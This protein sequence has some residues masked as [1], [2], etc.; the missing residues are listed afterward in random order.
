MITMR[1]I[2]AYFETNSK[3]CKCIFLSEEKRPVVKTWTSSYL[4]IQEELENL[5]F[6]VVD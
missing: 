4:P 5:C 2:L 1:K 3:I 6:V